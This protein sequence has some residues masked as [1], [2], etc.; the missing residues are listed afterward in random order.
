ME[1]TLNSTRFQ[2]DNLVRV[3][4][5]VAL[6]TVGALNVTRCGDSDDDASDAARDQYNRMHRI[7]I[8]GE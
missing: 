3:L 6:L 1:T 4:L 5:L 2:F 8:T 7:V